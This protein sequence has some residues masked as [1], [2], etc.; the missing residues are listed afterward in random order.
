MDSVVTQ[1]LARLSMFLTAELDF[2]VDVQRFVAEPE[3][4]V[5]VLGL[6]DEIGNDEFKVIAA[7]LRKQQ[8][9]RFHQKNVSAQ[10][11]DTIA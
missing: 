2:H 10:A 7:H 11:S 4:A 3:Y 5:Q 8:L 9:A 6:V 1:Q